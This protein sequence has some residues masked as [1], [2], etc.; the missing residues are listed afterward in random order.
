M[1]ILE[2]LKSTGHVTLIPGKKIKLD[3]YHEKG[4]HVVAGPATLQ[5]SLNGEDWVTPED[6]EDMEAG[7]FASFPN[8]VRFVRL[9]EGSASNIKVVIGVITNAFS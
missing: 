6:Y 8:F 7:Y 5:L 9:Q 1:S 4:I 3:G 2:S